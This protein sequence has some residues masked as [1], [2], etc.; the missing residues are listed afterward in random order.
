MPVATSAADEGRE[1][2]C[3]SRGAMEGKEDSR[4]QELEEAE[5]GQRVCV[6]RNYLSR[7]FSSAS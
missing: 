7:T 3:R 6:N 1:K 5:Q 4:Q 2:R